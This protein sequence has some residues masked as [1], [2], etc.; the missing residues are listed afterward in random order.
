[1]EERPPRSLVP[2]PGS[3]LYPFQATHASHG[4]T[5]SKDICWL[6]LMQTRKKMKEKEKQEVLSLVSTWFLKDHIPSWSV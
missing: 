5:V 2:E 1:M 3:S 6:E 4:G